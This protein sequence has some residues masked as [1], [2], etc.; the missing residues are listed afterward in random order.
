MPKEKNLRISIQSLLVKATDVFPVF[1]ASGNQDI[2]S[3]FFSSL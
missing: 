2:F 3:A 1:L